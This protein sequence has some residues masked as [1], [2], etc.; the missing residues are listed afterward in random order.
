MVTHPANFTP[1]MS[2]E[3]HQRQ[4]EKKIEQDYKQL[5]EQRRKEA[6]EKQ[7]AIDAKAKL[8]SDADKRIAF[9]A[10]RGRLDMSPADVKVYYRN[11]FPES[12]YRGARLLYALF[13]SERPLRVAPD[14]SCT[15]AGRSFASLEELNGDQGLNKLTGEFL[16]KGYPDLVQAFARS[17]EKNHSYEKATLEYHAE[18]EALKVDETAIRNAPPDVRLEMALESGIFEEALFERDEYY[19][20]RAANRDSRH[21]MSADIRS[22]HRLGEPGYA[23]EPTV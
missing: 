12:T 4:A 14:G 2:P 11:G 9:N 13:T 22:K 18:K 10:S 19:G 20:N 8:C 3:Q 7:G 16:L 5:Q 21:L 1:L 15:L 17:A 6:A 23:S